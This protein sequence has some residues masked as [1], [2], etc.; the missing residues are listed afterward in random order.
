MKQNKTNRRP[1]VWLFKKCRGQLPLLCVV[2]FCNVLLAASSVALALLVKE[3]IDSA[4]A[5]VT[6]AA[7]LSDLY[8]AAVRACVLIV[9]QLVLRFLCR[10]LGEKSTADI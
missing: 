2:I 5:S 3:V 4:S 8:R 6:D 7:F 10:Y 9:L 1:L